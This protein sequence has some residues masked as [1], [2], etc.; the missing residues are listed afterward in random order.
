MCESGKLLRNE[1]IGELVKKLGSERKSLLPILQEIQKKFHYIDEYSQQVVAGLLSIHPVEV[2]SVISFYAF[3]YDKPTG[4]NIVRVCKN[5]ICEF[6]GSKGIAKA[7]RDELGIEFDQTTEDGRVTLEYASCFG[8]CD[9][10]PSI[11]I[12]DKIH[13]RVNKE[14]A[15]NLIRKL[16]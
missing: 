8:M 14:T 9:K 11:L 13:E 16:K 12:N 1:F 10:S 3:L 5:I 2:N 15:L 4:R 7:L 6:H